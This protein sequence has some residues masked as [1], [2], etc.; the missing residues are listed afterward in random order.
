M[1]QATKTILLRQ[2]VVAAL[3]SGR[4]R[5]V[6]AAAHV[7]RF[8]AGAY[9]WRTGDSPRSLCVVADGLLQSSVLLRSGASSTIE[10]FGRGDICGC[11]TH[12]RAGDTL[13]D[14]RAVIDSVVVCFPADLVFEA[15]KAN[16]KWHLALA[17]NLA[18]RF[19]R[20]IRL[21]SISFENSRRKIPSILIW[22]HETTGVDIPLTQAVLA[23][24]AGLSQ[25]T[26]CRSL[27]SLKG[28]GLVSV[29]RGLINIPRPAE[30][31]KYLETL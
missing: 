21:R 20:Q 24:I 26:V 27:G 4:I 9:L 19:E 17:R 8:R 1:D 16:P 22:L 14:L 3:P 31:V 28:R 25:G 5:A 11:L 12:L 15:E 6:L 30:L 18:F 2:P 29:S 7:R 13:C 23:T 10:L